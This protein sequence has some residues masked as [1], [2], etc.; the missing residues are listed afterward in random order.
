MRSIII[1]TF[2]AACDA[3]GRPAGAAPGPGPGIYPDTS[4]SGAETT[5]DAVRLDLPE[6][7]PL[8][9]LPGA[10]TT[11]GESEDSSSGDTSTGETT[12]EL[13]AS[14]S[15]ASTSTTGEDE[16]T[17]A[18]S[19]ES[20]GTST[21]AAPVCEDGVCDSAERAPCWGPGWCLADCVAD[22]VCLS[23]CACTEAAAA[24]MNFCS[25]D[26]KPTCA[27]TMP[28]GYCDP[29]GD[30]SPTDADFTRGFYEWHA[31]CG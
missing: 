29:N 13:D 10:E 14:T 20:S 12:L 27:A 4:T 8:P 9:N 30:G 7:G 28:G 21:G 23:D 22:P 11:T 16:S 2:I 17:T 6:H 19:S 15:D 24:T 25:A 31:K 5:G 26:P 1:F 18:V 3:A